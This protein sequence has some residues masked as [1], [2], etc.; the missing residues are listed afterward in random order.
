MEIANGLVSGI[1]ATGISVSGA[2]VAVK[3]CIVRLE[4]RVAGLRREVEDHSEWKNNL[5]ETLQEFSVVLGK[6]S[7]RLDKMD[8]DLERIQSKIEGEGH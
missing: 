5:V 1:V 3:V 8:K 4:E 2:Y 7:V 6:V